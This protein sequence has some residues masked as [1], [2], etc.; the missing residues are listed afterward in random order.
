MYFVLY[1]YICGEHF[2]Y[3][4]LIFGFVFSVFVFQFGYVL[5]PPYIRKTQLRGSKNNQKI[6]KSK[7]LRLFLCF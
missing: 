6:K 7:F 5:E 2:M 3:E 4:C 1:T